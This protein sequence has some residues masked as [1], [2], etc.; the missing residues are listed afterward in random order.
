ML[1]VISNRKKAVV[2]AM[3]KMRHTR[4]SLS[5]F[6]D[7][8]KSHPVF[9]VRSESEYAHAHIPGALS[10][11]IF[12]DE[13]RAKIGTAYKQVSKE[14]AIE[15]GFHF[16]GPRLNKYIAHVLSLG[17]SKDS[18]LLLHCWRGGMRS[19]AMSWLMNFYGFEAYTL[20]GGYKAFRNHVLSTFER[21]LPAIIIGG[22][23]GS[24][25][26]EILHTLQSMDET[27]LDLE[28]V[29]HHRG[30]SFGSIGCPEQHSQEMF[31]NMLAMSYPNA[32]IDHLWIEDE[33]RKI[34]RNILPQQLHAIIR[35]HPV[36]FLDIPQEARLHWLVEQYAEHDTQLIA[37]AVQRIS[38]RLGGLETSKALTALE[39]G[40][41]HTCFAIALK[42]YDDT[43]AFGLS[44]RDSSTIHRLELQEVNHEA[45]AKVILEY[46]NSIKKRNA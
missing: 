40:D 44:K 43:Y 33:S 9:D 29:A 8:A 19:E 14:S 11:P 24:G 39:K 25:K 10:L 7:L 16:F 15:L 23:T 35:S 21:S 2:F 1:S 32:P 20:E 37:Q 46:S 31:E 5:E 18:K 22:F 34:G 42:Y 12:T 41:L 17:I 4:I 26:T 28:A 36:I 13:E 27:I 38:K 30:S 45:N 3:N 6:L